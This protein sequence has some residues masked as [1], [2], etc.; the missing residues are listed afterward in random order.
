MASKSV[1]DDSSGAAAPECISPAKFGLLFKIRGIRLLWELMGAAI[2][3]GV[4][5]DA[6][7]KSVRVTEQQSSFETCRTEQH[8][9][10]IAFKGWR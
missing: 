9:R 8:F 4:L 1:S 6:N 3:G 2:T 5:N 7:D 10:G